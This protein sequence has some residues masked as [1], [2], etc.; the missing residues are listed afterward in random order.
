MDGLSIAVLN[1][2]VAISSGSNH[3]LIGLY[4]IHTT[5]V[6]VVIPAC[7]LVKGLFDTLKT[8]NVK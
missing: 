8:M 6:S 7:I 2:F 4:R 3:T 5:Y 1:F